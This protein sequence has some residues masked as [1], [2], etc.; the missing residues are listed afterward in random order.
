[1]C[2]MRNSKCRTIHKRSFV[3][4]KFFGK[5]AMYHPSVQKLLPNRAEQHTGYGENQEILKPDCFKIGI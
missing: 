4:P 2:Q 1:M 5:T 3:F